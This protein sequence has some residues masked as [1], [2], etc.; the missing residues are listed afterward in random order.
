MKR[1]FPAVAAVLVTLVVGAPAHATFPGA[2]GKI[3]FAD[4][5]SG[6]IYS[7]NPDGSSKKQLT[8]GSRT[9]DDPQWSPSGGRIAYITSGHKD[10]PKLQIMNAGG[11]SPKV[12][13]AGSKRHFHTMSSPTWSP[14]GGRI[15]FCATGKFGTRI[16]AVDQDGTHLS[17]LSGPH[18]ADCDPDWAP[19]GSKIVFRFRTAKGWALAKMD[20]DGTSRK[21]IVAKG[22]NEAPSYSPTST[23]IAFDRRTGH[24]KFDVAVVNVTGKGLHLVT[25][26]KGRWEYAP[27]WSPAGDKIVF[28]RSFGGKVTSPAD[29][30]VVN[31]DGTH[32]DQIT[33]SPG[34]ETTP[35]WQKI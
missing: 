8:T 29:L 22:V 30:W 3:A 19:D 35:S 9:A 16:F 27:A 12:V 28:P 33:N 32:G 6:R 24:G 34:S 17:N 7:A 25:K 31:P 21:T 14:T 10:G 1:L 13:L 26:T 23:R 4:S 2:N 18:R 11:G 20:T 15:A 5:R